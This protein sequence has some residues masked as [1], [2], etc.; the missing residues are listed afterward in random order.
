MERWPQNRNLGLQR[1]SLFH[2]QMVLP[3]MHRKPFEYFQT[4]SKVRCIKRLKAPYRANG[5]RNID[6]YLPSPW[7][8]LPIL[9]LVHILGAPRD[10][11]GGT[12]YSIHSL[13]LLETLSSAA[14]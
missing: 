14:P 11:D 12:P 6:R 2:P 1:L 7:R 8:S 5:H 10:R 4:R 3:K 13:D 9:V